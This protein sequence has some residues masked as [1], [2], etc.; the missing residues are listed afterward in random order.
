MVGGGGQVKNW[1]QKKVQFSK[2]IDNNILG[3]NLFDLN[4]QFLDALASLEEPWFYITPTNWRTHNF[5]SGGYVRTDGFMVSQ[6][7]SFVPSI[8]SDSHSIWPSTIQSLIHA[9]IMI[10]SNI[11][12][13]GMW[14][15]AGTGVVTALKIIHWPTSFL[16]CALDICSW[17]FGVLN[18]PKIK[19][20]SAHKER[21]RKKKN[22]VRQCT[23]FQRILSNI[24]MF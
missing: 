5:H 8:W 11:L 13:D 15:I 3:P 21:T 17:E 10:H 16:Y 18:H 12:W 24:L 14:W 19:C 1:R 4:F 22:E 2:N 20:S 9:F 23:Y 6:T 7:I